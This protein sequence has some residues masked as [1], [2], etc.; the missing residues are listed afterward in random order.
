MTFLISADLSQ[1]RARTP[2]HQA[3]A[4]DLSPVPASQAPAADDL[5]ENGAP[6]LLSG[7]LSGPSPPPLPLPQCPAETSALCRGIL[8]PLPD[9][10]A[11]P[12][13]QPTPS[14][15]CGPGAVANTRSRHSSV[16]STPNPRT[17][18][19]GPAGGR[20]DGAQSVA[21]TVSLTPVGRAQEPQGSSPDPGSPR[22]AVSAASDTVVAGRTLA[23]TEEDPLSRGA[24]AVPAAS[25]SPR[26]LCR[27]EAALTE[28]PGLTALVWDPRLPS[29]ADGEV[30]SRVPRTCCWWSPEQPHPPPPPWNLQTYPSLFLFHCREMSKEAHQTSS[31]DGR[32]RV[33]ISSAGVPL[34]APRPKS[35]GW[36]GCVRTTGAR[37]DPWGPAGH[38]RDHGSYLPLEGASSGPEG[39]RVESK[40]PPA[41]PWPLLVPSYTAEVRALPPCG[42]DL[43]G[44]TRH[45]AALRGLAHSPIVCALVGHGLGHR[46]ERPVLL[47]QA[48]V[49]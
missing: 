9:Q 45:T 13:V 31:Q 37:S 49:G 12:S 39:D 26:H 6:R 2:S 10:L 22:A 27:R 47:G 21:G 32:L 3:P 33:S 7:S 25:A 34:R 16:E 15:P 46:R 40:L 41:R 23:Q 43:Q 48:Q 30:G 36:G 1:G 29:A 14:R 4:W 44:S 11:L 17:G 5:A 28:S 19:R 35:A 8:H 38:A 42:T 18:T 24:S 20:A